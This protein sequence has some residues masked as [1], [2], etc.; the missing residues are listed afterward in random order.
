VGTAGAFLGNIELFVVVDRTVGTSFNTLPVSTAFRRVNDDQPIVP[1]T[2][3]LG[4]ADLDAGGILAVHAQLR[5][6]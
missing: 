6:K 2:D 3:G 5:D 1:L 4:G